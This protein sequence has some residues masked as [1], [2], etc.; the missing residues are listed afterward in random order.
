[1]ALK[2]KN[3]PVKKRRDRIA[4]EQKLLNTVGE[5]I[6][7]EGF[8]RLKTNHIAAKA[9]VAKTAIYRSFKNVDG[10]IDCYYQIKDYRLKGVRGITT[11]KSKKDLVRFLMMRIHKRYDFLIDQPDMRQ[12]MVWELSQ[13]NNIFKHLISR[14]T[15]VNTFFLDKVRPLLTDS[16]I[17]L[18]TACALAF[19]SVSFIALQSQSNIKNEF[20]M[21]LQSDHVKQQVMDA[22]EKIF[23]FSFEI[24]G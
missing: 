23:N 16:K 4:T 12:F 8:L 13:T 5:I 7:T 22:I 6:V 24:E 20:G 2:K 10:L 14:R 11:I 1:M 18:T 19:S 21:D 15:K 3:H 17:E 9:G